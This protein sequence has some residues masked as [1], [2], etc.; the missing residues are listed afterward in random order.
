[1]TGQPVLVTEL[2]AAANRLAPALEQLAAVIGMGVQLEAVPQL[3]AQP[4]PGE[5]E[6][7]L[8]YEH[9]VA[10]GVGHPHERRRGVRQLA[11]ASL[12][13]A[14]ELVVARALGRRA[15]H[16]RE[17]LQEVGIVRAEVP[18]GGA[19]HTDHAEVATSRGDRR[20]HRAHDLEPALQ[21]GGASPKSLTTTGP[22]DW[23]A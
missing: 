22:P 15:E 11:E 6:P 1:V 3:L 17:R 14:Y 10:F 8:V 16:V 23:S 2:L 7:A 13:V 4:V 12:A 9:N 21:G 18:P 5:A 19:V 20:D